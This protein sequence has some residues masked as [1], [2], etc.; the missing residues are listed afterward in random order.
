MS[1]IASE[2]GKL[3]LFTCCYFT[4]PFEAMKLTLTWK[5]FIKWV[6][7]NLANYVPEQSFF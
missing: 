3:S 2:V 4:S 1:S 7:V 6:N 5:N